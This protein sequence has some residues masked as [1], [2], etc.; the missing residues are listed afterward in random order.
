MDYLQAE[1]FKLCEV[2]HCIS[3]AEGVIIVIYIDD[4][5][6]VSKDKIQ[7]EELLQNL[8]KKTIILTDEGD[9]TS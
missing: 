3:F 7:L 8:K 4:C 5:L 9:I 1:G 6:I 2:H